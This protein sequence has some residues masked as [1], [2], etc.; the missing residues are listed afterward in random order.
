MAIKYIIGKTIV[1]H[2]SRPGSRIKIIKVEN[3][4]ITVQAIN[5]LPGWEVSLNQTWSFPERFIHTDFKHIKTSV[6]K[7]DIPWL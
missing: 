5:T 3:G 1:E 4:Y 7:K 2:N 6:I